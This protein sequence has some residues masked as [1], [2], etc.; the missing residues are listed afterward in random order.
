MPSLPAQRLALVAALWAV[1]GVAAA[2]CADRAAASGVPGGEAAASPALV[3]PDD[4]RLTY[5]GHWGVTAA[6]ATTV[7]SGS[8]L[9]LRFTGHALSARF[10]TASITMPSQVY[11]S[12]DGS[13]PRLYKVD[14]D[15][16]DFTPTPLAGGEHVAEIDVKDVDEYENRWIA[17]LQSGV[18][19]TGL[20]LS[21]RG[22]LLAGPR[23][24]RL[25]LEFYGDSITE[26]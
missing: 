12:I 14:R 25:R 1:A 18:V 21:Q 8:R 6:S 7:N 26:A 2:A 3:R 5:E 20:E 24:G 15:E 13:A 9:M 19:L 22:Q 17:P 23:P 4:R 10:D 16:I 11:V